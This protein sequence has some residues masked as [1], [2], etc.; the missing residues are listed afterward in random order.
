MKGQKLME[1]NKNEIANIN[2]ELVETEEE[3]NI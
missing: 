2:F 3:K 1:E